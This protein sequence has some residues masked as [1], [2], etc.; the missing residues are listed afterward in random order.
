M[1]AAPQLIPPTTLSNV[2]TL[3]AG[4]PNS[5]SSS[6]VLGNGRVKRW[7]QNTDGQLGLGIDSSQSIPQFVP[8]L[9]MTGLDATAPST[10]VIG[11]T[12]S[13]DVGCF[14]GI[15][16]GALYAFD[17]RMTGSLP[18]TSLPGLGVVPHVTG[19]VG[20]TLTGAALRPNPTSSAPLA[21]T[22]LPVDTQLVSSVAVVNS[23][24]PATALTSCGEALAIFGDGFMP[25]ATV[26]IGGDAAANVAVLDQWVITSRHLS[27]PPEPV[28]SS[29]PIQAPR[30]EHGAASSRG[31]RHRSVL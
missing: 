13:W 24:L 6:A 2:L 14:M 27:M 3:S 31:L 4:G 19:L 26:T 30:Q 11:S 5:Y 20:I 8:G 22:T 28:A 15:A 1:S 10:S 17:L 25:G 16:S 29:S 18:V 21:A 23:V 9:S 12:L 7:G